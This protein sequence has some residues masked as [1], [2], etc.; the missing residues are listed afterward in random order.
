MPLLSPLG[1]RGGV[2]VFPL[3]F[4]RPHGGFTAMT[5]SPLVLVPSLSLGLRSFDDCHH[6]V[7]TL[8]A[9]L[10]LCLLCLSAWQHLQSPSRRL[11]YQ[12][13]LHCATTELARIFSASSSVFI[14]HDLQ[15]RQ[16]DYLRRYD[17]L[18]NTITGD[19]AITCDATT[20]SYRRRCDY[21][22]RYDKLIPATLRLPATLRQAYQRD[23]RRR[24]D[25]TLDTASARRHRPL[26]RHRH[27]DHPTSVYDSAAHVDNLILYIL[28]GSQSASSAMLVLQPLDGCHCPGSACQ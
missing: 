20:S 17:K 18:T 2:G 21:L 9:R 15:A 13:T 5:V 7:H 19:A 22:R 8:V 10:R 12:S 23:Y 11:Y 26:Q 24:Y 16:H 27:H 1:A 6:V 25:T 14:D 28:P 4:L 3:L